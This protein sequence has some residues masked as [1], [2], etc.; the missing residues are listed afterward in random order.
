MSQSNPSKRTTFTDFARK[1]FS[2]ALNGIGQF[3]NRLGI[4]PNMITLTGLFGHIIAA[5]IIIQGQLQAAAVVIFF[6]GIL[7]GIDGTVARISGKTTGW[8]AFLDSFT[9]RYSEIIVLG[10]LLVHFMQAD[11]LTGV[12]LVYLT[13]TGSLMVSYA[14]AR[15]QSL[16]LDIKEGL[17]SRFERYIIIVLSMLFGL[18][19]LGMLILAIGTH[20]TSI[21]RAFVLAKKVKEK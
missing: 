15:S 21:Q 2:T 3:L 8:G 6:A 18:H 9:D 12:I 10:G 17:F 16:G 14:R 20:V 5:V 13:I 19:F 7:D 4:H 1:V 11:Q